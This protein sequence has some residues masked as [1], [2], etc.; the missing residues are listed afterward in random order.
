MS[1]DSASRTIIGR[2]PTSSFHEWLKKPMA[3]PP[4]MADVI[5]MIPIL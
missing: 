1:W 2:L 5:P 3:I 4:A